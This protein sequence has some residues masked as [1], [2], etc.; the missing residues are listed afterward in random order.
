MPR[1]YLSPPHLSGP[2]PEQ[3]SDAFAPS[4]LAPLGPRA[5]AFERE[6]AAEV[7]V[8][9]AA[10][11]RVDSGVALPAQAGCLHLRDIERGH[12]LDSRFWE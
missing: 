12:R 9:P 1:S 6:F 3:V 5:D 10:A 4:W 7:G 2:E 11:E 8:P